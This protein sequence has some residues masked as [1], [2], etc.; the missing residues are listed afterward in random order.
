M[1]QPTLGSRQGKA[2]VRISGRD[3]GSC[4]VSHRPVRT[5]IRKG[6]GTPINYLAIGLAPN[7]LIQH[8]NRVLIGRICITPLV[9]RTFVFIS[10]KNGHGIT[11]SV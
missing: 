4:K 8:C 5:T 2:R 3:G 6:A 1:K 9:R 10:V 11:E 7:T